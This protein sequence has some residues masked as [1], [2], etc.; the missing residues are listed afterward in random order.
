M[1]YICFTNNNLI[2]SSLDCLDSVDTIYI[3]L[4]KLNKS[5]RQGHTNSW[6]SNH[7]YE[8]ILSIRNYVKSSLLGVRIDPVNL[9]TG[10]QINRVIKNG[11]DV[12]MLPMFYSLEEVKKV[13]SIINKRVFLDLLFE[14][15]Q[16]LEIIDLIPKN[17]IR[18]IHFGINDLSLAFSYSSMFR[19]LFS[20]KLE[21]AASK[22]YQREFE[23]G[24]GGV[25]P[26][27]SKPINPELLL[28]KMI[29]LKANR[30]ILSRSFLKEID[31]TDFISAKKSAEIKLNELINVE[32]NLFDLD[33]S[34][35]KN[36]I[37]LLKKFV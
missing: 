1:K 3:D 36:K 22:A 26:L 30:V 31:L 34:E 13:I 18:K 2:A 4:E 20:D 21:F 10:K 35:I 28:A 7:T 16:S 37:D 33:N 14:T 32:R 29:S 5:E 24:L 12:I 25:G 15:P 17:S 23:F 6:I 8:D 9:N 11:A 19:C 27:G